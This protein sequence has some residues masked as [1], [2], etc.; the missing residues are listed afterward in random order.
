MT[1]RNLSI[2]ILVLTLLAASA[3][4]SRAGGLNLSWSDC[5]IFGTS[6]RTFA[7]NDNSRSF[8]IIASAIPSA[9]MTQLNG[10]RAV[11]HITTMEL[12]PP[13]W[14]QLGTGGCR[15][16]ALSANFDFTSSTFNCLDVWG[17]QATGG[18]T[19]TAGMGTEAA[20]ITLS[21]AVPAGV[22]VDDQTEMYLGA[23]VLNT[24]KTTGTGSCPGCTHP[25]CIWL[26]SVRLMQPAGVG[27][28][29]ITNW[30]NRGSV[31][32]LN[33]VPLF[34]LSCPPGPDPT[35][36]STWGGVKSLYR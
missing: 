5:G 3:V 36:R 16:G 10:M 30:L 24:T 27:D 26:D 1:T 12:T 13:S 8:P 22:S 35:R 7:C 6:F 11:L 14:W 17:G 2:S 33:F 21:C 15:D 20:T 19:Y 4:P 32:W 18:L 9:P 23:I 28:Q 34:S 31:T 25:A 29:V